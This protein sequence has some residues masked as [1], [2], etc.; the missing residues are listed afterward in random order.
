MVHSIFD[1]FD[2]TFEGCQIYAARGSGQWPYFSFRKWNTNIIYSWAIMSMKL[3]PDLLVL[4][5]I[6]EYFNNSFEV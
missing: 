5:G 1:T 2:I 3:L 4:S 6:A